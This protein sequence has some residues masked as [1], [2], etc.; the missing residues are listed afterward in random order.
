[1]EDNDLFNFLS[2]KSIDL[3]D[4]DLRDIQISLATDDFF[5]ED[6]NFTLI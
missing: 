6:P 4:N 2:N 5:K 3:V 1:M